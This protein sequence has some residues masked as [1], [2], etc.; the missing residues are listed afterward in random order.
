VSVN[1]VTR[2]RG[3]ITPRRTRQGRDPGLLG[4]GNG[5]GGTKY[6]GV[7]VREISVI[8]KDNS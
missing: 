4:T 2:G 7:R 8:A 5:D 3:F 1:K 6:R